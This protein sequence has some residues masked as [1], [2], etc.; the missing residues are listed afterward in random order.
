MNLSG[1]LSDWPVGELLTVMKVT[2]KTATLTIRGD[3]SGSVDFVAGRVA[4]AR[5]LGEPPLEAGPGRREA[6]ADALYLL[7]G[8]TTGTFEVVRLTAE[9]DES[10]EVEELLAD[11]GQ[12]G[13][14]R[15]DLEEAGLL[16]ADLTLRAE[17]PVPVT[18]PT[19]DWWALASLV[20]ILSYS[21]LEEVFG[22]ARATRL[23]HTLWRLDVIEV[24]EDEE[25]VSPPEA[26]TPLAG[27][28]PAVG[29]LPARG[30]ESWLDEIAAASEEW[31]AT[32]RDESESTRRPV[33]GVAAP[34]STVLTGSVLDEMRR[35]RGR[36][37]A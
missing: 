30:D 25:A 22:R 5:I 2:A 3:V 19:E 32:S 16:V 36:S 24:V 14:L 13:E 29:E 26:E 21:Q 20:S 37:G 17:V 12:L 28:E 7:S 4:D 18:I 15:R 6:V 31:E 34:P 27:D 33:L 35:L 10:W 23:L 9:A 1:T 11:M 8:A